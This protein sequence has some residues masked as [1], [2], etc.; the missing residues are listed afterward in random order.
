MTKSPPVSAGI[1]SV[2]I[3]D[4]PTAAA[5]SIS[6]HPFIESF[7]HSLT[8]KIT[9]E[10][11]GL[12]SVTTYYRTGIAKNTYQIGLALPSYDNDQA[13]TNYETVQKLKRMADPKLTD[14]KEKTG[15]VK[16]TIGNLIPSGNTVGY[17][18]AVE[19]TMDLA[20]GFSEE[21]YPKLIKI[22]FTFAVDEIYRAKSVPTPVKADG[23][24]NN[25]TDPASPPT[26]D[27]DKALAAKSKNAV[28]GKT[29]VA[30]KAK[31]KVPCP[32]PNQSFEYSP[33]RE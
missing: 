7:K 10:Q 12:F 2:L 13:K 22:N 6:F 8:P 5:A 17:I 11:F 15:L 9:E 18:I 24:K 32:P 14:L 3:Y 21:G 25:P 29:A 16:V 27:A 1:N 28:A 30:G 19:E 26:S 23:K 4:P 33:W 20:H 31:T